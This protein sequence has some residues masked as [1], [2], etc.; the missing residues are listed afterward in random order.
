MPLFGN[1]E[2]VKNRRLDVDTKIPETLRMAFFHC[3]DE[4]KIP[5]LLHL[6]KEVIP[7]GQQSVVFCATRHHVEYLHLVLDEAGVSN[8]FI[9]SH[10]GTYYS[11]ASAVGQ[12][13]AGCMRFYLDK[14]VGGRVTG[15]VLQIRALFSLLNDIPVNL[16]AVARERVLPHVNLWGTLQLRPRVKNSLL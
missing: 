9:Y 15:R 16:E 2:G 13:V 5:A 8:T 12:R 7:A 6:L 3:R 10:L 11:W 1:F 4:G 14:L